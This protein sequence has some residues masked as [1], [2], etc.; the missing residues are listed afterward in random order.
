VFSI[1]KMILF[2]AIDV[3]DGW[4]SVRVQCRVKVDLVVHLL[5]SALSFYSC[6]GLTLLLHSVD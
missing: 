1:N 6:S 4:K 5:S 2:Q 3:A